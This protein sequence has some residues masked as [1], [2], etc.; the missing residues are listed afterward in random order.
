LAISLAAKLMPEA[1]GGG[2]RMAPNA[3]GGGEAVLSVSDGGGAMAAPADTVLNK[4]RWKVSHT[5]VGRGQFMKLNHPT[6]ALK[7]NT[8]SPSPVNMA[9]I[10]Y[11]SA[12]FACCFYFFFVSSFSSLLSNILFWSFS[13]FTSFKYPLFEFSF[14]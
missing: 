4:L 6:H 13:S 1:T 3:A 10:Y 12:I 8:P 9:D 5:L 14:T 11:F 2:G 7:N